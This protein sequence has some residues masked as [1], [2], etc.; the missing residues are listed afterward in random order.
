MGKVELISGN[1]AAAIGAK[2]SRVQVISAYP[3]TPQTPIVEYLAEFI[4]KGELDAEYIH[5][6]GEHSA[7]AA[8]VAASI[9]GAR[10]FT[11]TCSQG[12]AYGFEC[13]A[14]A[15]GYRVPL[16]MAIANRTTGWYWSLQPDYS[17]IMPGRDLGFLITFCESVQEILDSIIQMYKI[18]EHEK[19]QL[20]GMVSFEGF[21]L[22][23]GTEA[24]DIPDQAEVD[25]FL[26]PRKILPHVVDPELQPTEPF[27][28]IE[29]WQHTIYRHIFERTLDRAKGIVEEVTKEYAEKFG[30]D[31]YG[32]VEEYKTDGADVALVSMGCLTTAARRAVDAMR[33]E[34]KRVGLIKVR[35]YRPFPSEKIR[36]IVE[37]EGIKAL[38]VVDR[39]ISHGAGMG[40][41]GQDVASAL[42]SLK[43]RPNLIDFVCGMGGDDVNVDDFRRALNRL[44]E[45][46]DKEGVKELEF[47]E[48]PMKPERM[49]KTFENKLIAPGYNSCPGC[50][51]I[52]AFRHAA[53]I[54][55]KD[56]V[57]WYP[58]HCLGVANP[59]TAAPILLANFAAG[60]AYGRGLYRAYK[61]KGRKT[62]VVVFAGDGG[63]V[64][65][66]LQSLSSAAEAGES[67]F[68]ICYD[69]EA[70]MN[71]GIQRSGSTPLS[72]WTTT[73]PVGPRWRGKREERKDM[74][75]IMIAHRIPY[76][77][78]ASPAFMRD[79]RGKIEKGA[80][81]IDNR[82]G[83]AYLHIFAP[84]PTGWR[85]DS[86]TT[87][88]LARLAVQTG[89]WP[90]VEVDHGVF[91][92][93]YKPKEL[94]PVEEYLKLQGR[95]A[96]LTAEEISSIQKIV[97]ERYQK[98]L[99]M[100]GKKLF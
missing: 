51:A 75:E 100:D 59:Q 18:T 57:F 72:A 84:C 55:G 92:L 39:A 88:Q 56:T 29:P 52:L 87:I 82:E 58:P 69:N 32:L 16:V 94:R 49:L 23:H 50:G 79:M 38:G 86:N 96:H 1:R 60:A 35:F 74:L 31:V 27:Y 26:P 6:E 34:G 95:F 54:L 93:T 48:H 66:G 97:R 45:I 37:R 9:G 22:S 10:A 81:V 42:Y 28:L 14:Q 71:T 77:A 98:L 15:P 83:L 5:A 33:S 89:V 24:A 43:S 13:I 90:L 76:I 61:I 12:F 4:A 67:I 65:I 91:R 64:D 3:I 63:T 20:P 7:I 11:A 46:A 80:K 41:L 85:S 40:P 44:L 21:Y 36:E 8:A 2:L 53:E 78:F 99:E 25:D 19:V 68:F 70:Y 17:D 62:R 30:R 47:I 73:T